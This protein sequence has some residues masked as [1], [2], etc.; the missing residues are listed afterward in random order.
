V[1][2]HPFVVNVATLRRRP[3]S[4]RPVVVTGP[5]S[6][7]TVSASG[8][9]DGTPVVSDL[10]L[11]S[12]QGEAVLA[13]G[14]VEARWEGACRRCLGPASGPL[15]I[16]VREL[17]EARPDEEDIYPL[18]GDQIDLEPLVRDAVLLELPQA[19]LCQEGC[20]GLCPTCGTNLNEGTCPCETEV[21]DPRWAALDELRERRG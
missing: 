19:P 16:E 5:L 12:L 17:F 14:T 2:Q 10:L 1:A 9:P 6:G 7:L 11:E 4:R 3:G 18:S 20:R 8:V 13:T 21:R 15:A